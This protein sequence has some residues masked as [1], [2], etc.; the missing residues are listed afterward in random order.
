MGGRRVLIVGSSVFAEGIAQS[1]SE[2]AQVEVVGILPTGEA[3]STWLRSEVADVVIVTGMNMNGD[4]S[5]CVSSILLTQPGLPVIYTDLNA[6]RVQVI[7]SE[8]VRASGADL[9]AAIAALPG[10]L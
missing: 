7:T 8:C 4:A 1:L 10:R 9:L 6:D 2:G 3:A 5:Q